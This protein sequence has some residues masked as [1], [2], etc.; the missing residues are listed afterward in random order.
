MNISTKC[1]CCVKE[2]VCKHKDE[3]NA[4]VSEILNASWCTGGNR[5]VSLAGNKLVSVSIKC[6][7]MLPQS[8]MPRGTNS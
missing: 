7:K 3:Y 8:A 1:N 2:D 4:A 5:I 6:D